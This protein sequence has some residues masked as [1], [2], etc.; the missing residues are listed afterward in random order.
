MPESFSTGA[1]LPIERPRGKKLFGT[2]VTGEMFAPILSEQIAE[3]NRL[4]NSR[5]TVLAVPNTYF[6][7]DVSVAG[8]LSGQD[9]VAVREQ[10]V[11]DFLIIPSHI[12]KSDEPIM[13]DGMT[14]EELRAKFD[15]PVWPL[16][17]NDLLRFLA[18]GSAD[19]L[20]V[21]YDL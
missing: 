18:D 20:S 9:L 15:V 21:S 19:P 1:T 3:Y 17:T 13:I 16:D 11:G 5:L 8:L 7:G 12:I 10:V 6:G 14:F 4:T 2:I